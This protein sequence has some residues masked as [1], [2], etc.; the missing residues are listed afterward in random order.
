[1]A[2]E[3]PNGPT[4]RL[5]EQVIRIPGRIPS[6][7]PTHLNVPGANGSNVSL[8]RTLSEQGPGYVAPKFEGKEQQKE[9][10]TLAI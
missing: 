3:I 4:N 10:G 1:M 2:V 8:H 6:P 5:L 9:Q 7:Q